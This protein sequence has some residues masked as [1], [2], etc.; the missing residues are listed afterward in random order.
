MRLELRNGSIW[1][2]TI[3]SAMSKTPSLVS[4]LVGWLVGIPATVRL[5][6]NKNMQEAGGSRTKS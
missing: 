1:Q 4:F 3:P 2:G 6:Y 5:R